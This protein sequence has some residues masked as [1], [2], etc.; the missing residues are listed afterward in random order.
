MLVRLLATKVREVKQHTSM[1]KTRAADDRSPICT[2]V[3]AISLNEVAATK[4]Q[5]WVM[6][7]CDGGKGRRAESDASRCTGTSL[8]GLPHKNLED[9][10]KRY[11]VQ[12]E[13]SKHN[14]A[15]SCLQLCFWFPAVSTPSRRKFGK[16]KLVIS[17]DCAKP[18]QSAHDAAVYGTGKFGRLITEL[19]TATLAYR[20]GMPV[21]RDTLCEL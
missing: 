7:Q 3:P 21:W 16:E 14:S 10:L 20:T 12:P 18:L 13:N 15:P 9:T 6:C 11:V 17:A 4:T 8:E 5:L 19:V 1:A 2:Y